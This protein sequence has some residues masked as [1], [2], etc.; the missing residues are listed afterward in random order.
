MG[1]VGVSIRGAEPRHTLILVD[2]QPIMGDIS[3]Y[4]GQGDELQRLGTENVER[5][6]IIKGAASAK[7]GAD[8]IGGVI[9][10]ITKKAAKIAGM[11][12]NVEGRRIKGN[13]DIFPYQNIF[14][15]AD[16]GQVGKFRV[17][18]YGNKRDIMPIYS[19]EEHGGLTNGK[20]MHNSLRY[21]GDIKNIGLMGTYDIDSR[22]SIDFSTDKTKEDLSRIVKHTNFQIEGP[23]NFKRTVDRDTYRLTYKGSNGNNTDWNVDVNYSK[24]NEEDLTLTSQ[25]GSTAYEGKNTLNYIDDLKHKE[26]NVKTTA[27]TQINDTHLLTYGIGYS[28]ETA[29]GSRLKSATNHYI[30]KIQPR[31]YDSNLYYKNPSTVHDYKIIYKNG[32]PIYDYNYERYGFDIE[33]NGFV[34]ADNFLTKEKY[35]MYF[36]A[37]GNI[38]SDVSQDIKDSVIHPF[39]EKL[40]QQNR[41]VQWIDYM[42]DQMLIQSYYKQLNLGDDKNPQILTLNGKTYLQEYTSRA[43]Q[44]VVGKADIQK[45]NFFIQDTW[46]LNENTILSPIFRIDHSDTFGSHATFNLGV[47]HNING[48]AHRRIKANIGTGYTEPGMGELYYNWEMYP[49]MPVGEG[50]GKMGYYWIGNPNLKPE[51]AINVDLG[52]EGENGKT[53][54]RINVFHNNITDYMTAYFTGNL[55]DFYPDVSESNKWIVPPDMIYSFKN[56]GKAEITG[57]EAEINHTFNKHWSG[58]LGYTYL[59]AIN[60]SNAELPRQL[61]DKPQH[62]VDIGITYNNTYW[63]ASIWGNY[64]IH[65]L[66]SNSVSGNGN[67]W[68]DNGDGT[69]SA[70]YAKAGCW[71]Y[72]KK[73]FGIWNLLIQKQLSKDAKVYIGIDNIFNHHDDDRALQERVYKFGVN[74]KFGSSDDVMNKQLDKTVGKAVVQQDKQFLN[75]DWFI[76]R[77]FDI[78]KKEEI[79]I[80]GDYRMRWNSH[81]GSERPEARITTNGK[82]GMAKRN[83][84][85][86]AEHGFEQRLRLGVDARVGDNTNVKILGSAS[87]MSSVDTMYDVSD[88]KGMNHQR[89]DTVDVTQ[90]ADKW[91]F[92]VGRLTEPMGVTGYWFGK[93]YDGGRAVWT[94]GKNQ[95]RV[96]YG[97]FSHSTGITD[98]AY[99]HA[100]KETILRAPTKKEWLGIDS[101]IDA[102]NPI[103]K[104]GYDSIYNQLKNAK[105]L[106]EKNVIFNKALQ[107]ISKT[108]PTILDDLASVGTNVSISTGEQYTWKVVEIT[109]P[110][111]GTTVTKK[112]LL[113][114][115]LANG[116]TPTLKTLLDSDK[117]AQ[118]EF[119]LDKVKL[120]NQG[121]KNIASM[122]AALTR[123]NKNLAKS[124]GYTTTNSA[125]TDFDIGSK[126]IVKPV[127]NSNLPETF[128]GEY[129]GN[130]NFSQLSATT[131]EI[132]PLEDI[133]ASQFRAFDKETAYQKAL[134]SIWSANTKVHIS[135]MPQEIGYIYYQLLKKLDNHDNAN[136]QWNPQEGSLPLTETLSNVPMISLI[137][138]VLVQDTIPAIDRALFVQAK[139]QFGND[140]GVQAWYF[141]SANDDTHTY[142]AAHGDHNDTAS[143]DSLANVVGI[144]AKW[145]LGSQVTFSYDWGQNRT[146]F[147]RYMNGHTIYENHTEDN[148][149]FNF[150]GRANGGTPRFWVAR[151]DVG[152][153]DT[154]KPG[155]WN[156]FVDYKYFQHGSFFGGNGTEGLPDRYLDG[157]KSFTI[158]G[159]YVPSKDIL[160]EAFYTFGAKGIG[161]RDTLYGPESFTLG[162]YT[163]IQATFKF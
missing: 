150:G 70:A 68:Y 133:T 36:D 90:H 5:I 111:N 82:I 85:D 136:F 108:Y 129:T 94:S 107:I 147:G 98:S 67:Y 6:E 10:V 16:S 83:M 32:V 132:I 118:G 14:L 59:H 2:G 109:G 58:R 38:K 123:L 69:G 89:L 121:N 135:D 21:Y 128:Y 61:L 35:D 79:D 64:Y 117:L 122:E 54:H 9:N 114:T 152:H 65:M 130:K 51:K 25:Y 75:T 92:S 13:N 29:G 71:T 153:A 106:E 78:K 154:Q 96:G 62:K 120:E 97:D 93:E 163:R 50:V 49:G 8:A 19:Q 148:S 158:G 56:I 76:Q 52:L 81:T 55:L 1:R 126:V 26:F 105:T 161:Q 99:T 142:A 159:G 156:A 42:S 3:K 125:C 91:D 48:D 146:D 12:V 80:V 22:N 101:D 24:M 124:S 116:K 66:D 31:N 151:L 149:D 27:N 37:F 155:S 40:R 113:N 140:F 43:D 20:R 74:L 127:T 84:L 15:R 145:R 47:T 11:Q 45:E 88:S 73:T 110:K 28:K 46:Q 141:H 57:V 103:L 144:G 137:G 95:V 162:D 53:S 7:Y 131:G 100:V 4:S 44:Q 87:G 17:G 63:Q 134:D 143:F 119:A 139:H 33:N 18:V 60:K 39:A 112:Y 157:I 41:N 77:P 30:R 34:S 23:Q 138:T 72:A 160:L 102:K 115:E 104:S 86:K